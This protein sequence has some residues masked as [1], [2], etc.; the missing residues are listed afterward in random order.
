MQS[1][2]IVI[3]DGE[4]GVCNTS[5]EWAEARDRAR[6]LTFVPFQH[7]DPQVLSPGLNRTMIRRMAWLIAPDGRRYGGARCIYETL[8]RL[9]G[10][11]GVIGWLGANPVISLIA[12]PFYRVFAAN[13][14]RVSAMLGL[15]ECA[16]PP[17]PARP[18]ASSPH[19]STR[20]P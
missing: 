11:W 17:R 7:I 15:T 18:G 19:Y 8:K 1:P 20:L 14:H 6:R 4:C 9:P 13:R 10:V 16:V 3:Y 5:R 12:E 2:A